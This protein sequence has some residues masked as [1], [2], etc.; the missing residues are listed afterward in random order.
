MDNR[1]FP[2]IAHSIVD[3]NYANG[4]KFLGQNDFLFIERL[5]IAKRGQEPNSG[6]D[7]IGFSSTFL[8][9]KGLTYLHLTDKFWVD[10]KDGRRRKS[11]QL[12]HHIS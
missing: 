7:Q 1:I 6:Q 12:K 10:Q 9:I 5:R 2:K 11:V 3:G 8:L 4:K